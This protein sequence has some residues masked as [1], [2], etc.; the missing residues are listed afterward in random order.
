M[1]E[2]ARER[3]EGEVR[4][5]RREDHLFFYFGQILARRTRA[6]NVRLRPYGVD[7]ARWR[8]LAVLQEHSGV[9]MGRLAD[10]TSVDR[11]TLTRTLGMME[12]AELVV[13]RER[14]SDRRSLAIFLTAKGRRMLT[15]ILPLILKETDRALSGFSL[16]EIG[17]LRDRVKRIAENLRAL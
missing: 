16:M 10:L 2:R 1:L 7:Y 17:I 5:F 15:R 9:T 4:V 14:R 8:I 3:R 6:I 12:K 13:R 11:T